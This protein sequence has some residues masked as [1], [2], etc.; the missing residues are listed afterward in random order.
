MQK[1]TSESKKGQYLDEDLCKSL[2][3]LR[4]NQIEEERS[5]SVLQRKLLPGYIQKITAHPFSVVCYTETGIS[6]WHTNASSCVIFCDATG[7]LAS[8]KSKELPTGSSRT[9]LYYSLV[10]KHPVLK[11][12]PLAVAELIS[13]E[14]T[15]MAISHFLEVVRRA[16]GLLYSSLVKPRVVVIDQSVVP[17]RVITMDTVAH[18]QFVL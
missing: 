1:I 18:A 3:N 2:I 12:P 13:T 6:I 7:S 5:N 11:R 9:L 10:M 17:V 15:I 16:E 8:M 4:E 14:H